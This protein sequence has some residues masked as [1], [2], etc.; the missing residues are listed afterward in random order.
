MQQAHANEFCQ[1]LDFGLCCQGCPCFNFLN[2]A[3][4]LGY[5]NF[6]GSKND[7]WGVG[8]AAAI[9]MVAGGGGGGGCCCCCCCCCSEVILIL[10]RSVL[11]LNTDERVAPGPC[12]CRYCR[13]PIRACMR[14]LSVSAPLLLLLRPWWSLQRIIFSDG[15]FFVLRRTWCIAVVRLIDMQKCVVT[16]VLSIWINSS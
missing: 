4:N 11:L 5:Y 1:R 6:S 9:G 8:D 13:R 3:S 2:H 12:S 7:C 15:S 16:V 10:R 14:L